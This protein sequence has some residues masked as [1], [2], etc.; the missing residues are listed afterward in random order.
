MNNFIKSQQEKI[1]AEQEKIL[2]SVM[3]Q[4]TLIEDLMNKGWQD[5]T[6]RQILQNEHRID[7]V[8]TTFMS[9]FSLTAVL[10]APRASNLRKMIS[11]HEVVLMLEEIGDFL[12]NLTEQLQKVNLALPD[13]AEFQEAMQT[14]FHLLKNMLNAI[15]FSFFKGDKLFIFPVVEKGDDLTQS[16]RTMAANLVAVFQEIPLTGQEL[17]NV[18]SLHTIVFIMEKIK[19]LTIGIAKSTI[20][21]TEGTDIRHLRFDQQTTA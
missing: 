21:A 13:Y 16:A 11:S 15:V 7:E 12:V 14:M 20:F 10:Y 18:V 3:H 9:H 2:H 5:D 17:Q 4:F 6:Y 1:S 8:G 19:N